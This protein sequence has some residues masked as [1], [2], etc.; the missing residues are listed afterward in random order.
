[1]LCTPRA[2]AHPLCATRVPIRCKV[3]KIDLRGNNL[4]GTIPNG[5]DATERDYSECSW[6]APDLQWLRVLE[7][8]DNSLTGEFP[9]N[10]F[11]WLNT[12][13]LENNSFYGRFP[14]DM[15]QGVRPCDNTNPFTVCANT[16]S[17]KSSISPA[18]CRPSSRTG[19]A[20]E[21]SCTL[22]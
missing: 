22:A 5:T 7:L 4:T 20:T 1:M 2:I 18:R 17:G 8:Q 12:I 19:R 3:V 14:V 9:D 10:C 11:M 16:V 15:L 21:A 13:N 6:V